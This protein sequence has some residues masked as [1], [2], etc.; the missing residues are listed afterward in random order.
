MCAMYIAIIVAVMQWVQAGHVLWS[1][2]GCA[3]VRH[4]GVCCV[5]VKCSKQCGCAPVSDSTASMFSVTCAVLLNACANKVSFIQ[6][7]R[8]SYLAGGCI[9][10]MSGDIKNLVGKVL[11]VNNKLV[12]SKR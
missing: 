2:V 4:A 12:K 10:F 7:I 5:Q 11:F 8:C 9:G 6:R 3:I 1:H